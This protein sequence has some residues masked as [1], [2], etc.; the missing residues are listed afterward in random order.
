MYFKDCASHESAISG[1]NVTSKFLLLHLVLSNLVTKR[2]KSENR[3]IKRETI[4][5]AGVV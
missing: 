1:E 4:I 2:Q 5:E 3:I